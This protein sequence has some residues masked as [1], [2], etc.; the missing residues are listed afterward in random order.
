MENGGF[1]GSFEMGMGVFSERW[2][3]L[4]V[5]WLVLNCFYFLNEKSGFC[6]LWVVLR[7]AWVICGERWKLLCVLWLILNLVC[8]FS[9]F[10]HER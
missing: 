4:C 5:L 3:I 7:W 10:F 6:V 1:A 2:R 9:L 8:V